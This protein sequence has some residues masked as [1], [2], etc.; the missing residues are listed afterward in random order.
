VS[1]TIVRVIAAVAVGLLLS[2]VVTTPRI[3]AQTS[4]VDEPDWRAFLQW[5]ESRPPDGDPRRLLAGYSEELIRQ[6]ASADEARRRAAVVTTL[7]F[8]RPDGVRL[9]WD[10]VYAARNRIF[11]ERPSE[12]LVRAVADKTPG[13][14]LDVGMGQGRNALFLALNNWRVSGFDP[15]AG[16]IRQALERARSL[17]VTIDAAVT[18]DD[19]F[20]FGQ[21]RW[22]LIVVTYVRALTRADADRYWAALRQDGLVVYENSAQDGN[23][24]LDAFF[25]Y[26]IIRWEDVVDSPDWGTGDKTRIQRLVAQKA[27]R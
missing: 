18:T 26:R 2:L 9:L 10:K 12:L 24:V 8:R 21:E 11:S 13:R 16:G 20:E 17:G 14:A 19:R 23:G 1:S 3:R 7:V 25:A 5:L 22:D 27:R 4:A 6:G 15:S